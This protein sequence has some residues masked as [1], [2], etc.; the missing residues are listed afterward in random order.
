M[1]HSWEELDQSRG[2]LFTGEWPTIIEMFSITLEKFPHR[3]CFTSFKPER[4]TLTYA[5]V[6]S[7]MVR[8][9]SYLQE[10]G[11]QPGDRVVINGKNSPSWA[12]AYLAVLH[13]GAI[14]VPLDN[15]MPTRRME[16]LC[17]FCEA[18][19]VFEIGRAHV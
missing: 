13:A 11:V 15:Q 7:A 10:Q 1:Q 17:S 16:D 19:F 12:I 2:T 5:E 18:C 4:S 3:P 8:V 6:D 14:V 9:S